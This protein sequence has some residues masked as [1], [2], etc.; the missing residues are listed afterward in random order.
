MYIKPYHIV[1]SRGKWKIH[2]CTPSFCL[3][4]ERA[5]IYFDTSLDI[6]YER[7]N[8]TYEFCVCLLGFGFGVLY[9]RM[10]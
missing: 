8:G 3:D 7:E 1:F 10:K 9:L 4:G 6:T 2:I 5:G